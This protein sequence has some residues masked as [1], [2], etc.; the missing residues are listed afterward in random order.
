MKEQIDLIGLF[1]QNLKVL[2]D[3]FHD[4]INDYFFTEKELHSYFYHLS[5][6]SGAFNHKGHYLVHTEYPSP[7]KC[8]YIDDNPYI[9]Q[10]PSNSKTQRSHIDCVLINP[11]FIDWLLDHEIG[12]KPLIGIGNARFDLYIKNFYDIYSNFNKETREAILLY[13]IEF[14][15]LRHSYAG[16]KYP[17][18]GIHQ[19]IA[20]LRLLREFNAGMEYKINFV[21]RTKSVIFVG[22]RTQAAGKTIRRELGKYDPKEYVMITRKP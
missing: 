8:S 9:N 4:N 16:S 15:F 11:T 3:T 13:A 1:E 21:S 7:F 17:S 19:D 5:V 20:K 12:L 18:R 14:K 10:E 2:T 6:S 22:D